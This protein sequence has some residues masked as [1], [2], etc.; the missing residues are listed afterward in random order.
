MQTVCEI[1]SGLI[2][3]GVVRFFDKS[4]AFLDD[5]ERKSLR[6]VSLGNAGMYDRIFIDIAFIVGDRC[7]KASV[8]EEKAFPWSVCH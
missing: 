3:S 6:S 4:G 5:M 7:V 8:S 2:F 1:F